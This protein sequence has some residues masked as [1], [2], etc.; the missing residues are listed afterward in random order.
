MI[1]IYGSNNDFGSE[2][3]YWDVTWG[4]VLNWDHHSG[5]A[6]TPKKQCQNN[7]TVVTT[8]VPTGYY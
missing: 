1:K 6:I 2:R 4:N 8:T 7:M 5:T 3:P